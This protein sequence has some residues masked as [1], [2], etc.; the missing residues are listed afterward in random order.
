M[1]PD[2]TMKSLATDV[3]VMAFLGGMPD[4]YWLTDHRI[5]RACE[6]L[7]LHPSIAKDYAWKEVSE[8]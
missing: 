7:D 6:V 3:L 2:I 8:V 4:T 1:N 5:S